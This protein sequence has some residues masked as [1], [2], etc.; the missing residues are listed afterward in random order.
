[1]TIQTSRSTHVSWLDRPWAMDRSAGVIYDIQPPDL[2]A[3]R[4]AYVS[5]MT[6]HPDDPVACR[7]N[8]DFTRWESISASHRDAHAT[9]VIV[10]D[11]ERP[12][13]DPARY[14][15]ARVLPKHSPL[16]MRYIIGPQSGATFTNHMIGDGASWSLVDVAMATGDL[17]ILRAGPRASFPNMMRALGTHARQFARPWWQIARSR[18]PALPPGTSSAPEPETTAV[19]GA[20]EREEFTQL[21]AWRKAQLPGV[22]LTSV[23]ASA[24]WRALHDEGVPAEASVVNMLFDVRRHLPEVTPWWRGNTS[25]SI[26]LAVDLQDPATVH[27]AAHSTVET[28]RALPAIVQGAVREALSRRSMADAKHTRG[29][30]TLSISSMPDLPGRD[31][32]N[33]VDPAAAHYFGFGYSPIDTGVSCFAVAIAGR[34]EL[35]MTFDRHTVDPAVAQ[36]AINR[37]QDI[38]TL[39]GS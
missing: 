9:E 27:A 15:A 2:D 35:A 37:L 39:L 20:L 28:A 10:A 17:S 1:M 34:C 3:T 5:F 23:F 7:L 4:H 29:P 8:A 12:N 19:S 26:E 32:I 30:L 38:P 14:L 13:Q 25:K 16:T 11:P 6:E 21:N 36:R 31:L 18:P 22:G 24:F 33:W